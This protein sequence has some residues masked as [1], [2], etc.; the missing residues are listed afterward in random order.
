M[1]FSV[2]SDM[3][4]VDVGNKS[5]HTIFILS[6]KNVALDLDSIGMLDSAQSR[7]CF[8]LEKCFPMSARYASSIIRSLGTE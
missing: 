2:K 5:G 4:V 7:M 6:V 3:S 8:A 1:K